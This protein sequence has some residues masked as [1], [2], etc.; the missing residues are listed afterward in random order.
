MPFIFWLPAYFL[1]RKLFDGLSQGPALTA[2]PGGRSSALPSGRSS[3]PLVTVKKTPQGT[4]ITTSRPPTKKPATA[5]R[6]SKPQKIDPIAELLQPPK[7]KQGMRL[8][9]KV[10]IGPATIIKPKPKAAPPPKPPAPPKPAPRKPAPAAKPR[11]GMTLQRDDV[12]PD[13]G[14]A[15]KYEVIPKSTALARRP[16]QAARD[17]LAY[18]KQALKSKDAAKRLGTRN[19]PNAFVKAAQRDMAGGLKADGIYGP[20]SRMRG[21]AL[22]K[23]PFPSR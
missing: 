23:Q 3:A 9:P 6:T 1:A 4:R 16:E 10:T 17:L 11:A 5:A 13:R 15:P 12:R 7:P 20:A 14:M 19:A 21:Q 2:L 22:I 8:K 18:V